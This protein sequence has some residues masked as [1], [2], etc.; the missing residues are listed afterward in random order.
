MER[1]GIRWL[2]V[3][4]ILC[5]LINKDTKIFFLKTSSEKFAACFNLCYNN[6]KIKRKNYV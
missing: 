4:L 1:P 6:I 3:R 5:V 2:M